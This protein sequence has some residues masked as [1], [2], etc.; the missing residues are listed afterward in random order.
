[1]RRRRSKSG[2][3][4]NSSASRASFCELKKGQIRG[5]S[6]RV[7]AHAACRECVARVQQLKEEAAAKR[8]AAL[9]QKKQAASVPAPAAAAE[10]DDGSGSEVDASLFDWRA[11]KW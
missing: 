9:L 6:P 2:C 4:M 5:F 1:M 3:S 10:E 8:Q 11:K 7:H